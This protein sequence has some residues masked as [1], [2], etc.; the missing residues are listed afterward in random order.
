MNLVIS[1]KNVD[2]SDSLKS[3]IEDKSQTLK[4]YFD[5]KISANWTI[6][7]EKQNRI[8]HCRIKGNGMDYFGEGVTED[9]KASVDV[10]LDKI[11]TQIRKHK[12]VVKNHLHRNGKKE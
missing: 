3:F 4:K 7:T 10:A 12:E 6:S 2:T 1:F 9:F 8:A 11:E 5:G